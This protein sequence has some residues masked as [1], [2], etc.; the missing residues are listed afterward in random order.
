MNIGKTVVF[1]SV[2][3]V[4]HFLAAGSAT[5]IA[6]S[7]NTPDTAYLWS[8]SANWQDGKVGGAGD[9]VVLPNESVYI[10]VP[11]GGITVRRL[12]NLS[13]AAYVIGGDI[14]LLS[15]GEGTDAERRAILE[16]KAKIYCDVVIPEEETLNPYF[17]GVSLNCSGYHLCGRIRN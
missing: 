8:D 5:W 11:E 9:D 2:A 3:A 6:T 4:S 1:F 14:R 10:R 12:Q 15:A 16:T 13:S 7:A 17:R